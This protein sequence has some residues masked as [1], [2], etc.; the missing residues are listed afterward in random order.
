[1][2]SASGIALE[3]E[4]AELKSPLKEEKVKSWARVRVRRRHRASADAFIDIFIRRKYS[5]R[6]N[7]VGAAVESG[8]RGGWRETGGMELMDQS[9][10][11]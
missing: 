4:I 3:G 1:M 5:E 7:I 6:Y 11:N 10:S 9:G 2:R 8:E